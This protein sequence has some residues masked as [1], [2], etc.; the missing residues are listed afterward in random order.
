M[1]EYHITK[2]CLSQEFVPDWYGSGEKIEIPNEIRNYAKK[3]VSDNCLLGNK[4]IFENQEVFNSAFSEYIEEKKRDIEYDWQDL[5]T[6]SPKR[7][8]KVLYGTWFE[9]ILG[10][11]LS[12]RADYEDVRKNSVNGITYEQDGVNKKLECDV[13]C[14]NDKKKHILLM[15][16]KS[17]DLLD[18]AKKTGERQKF[19]NKKAILEKKYIGY[20]IDAIYYYNKVKHG[21]EGKEKIKDYYIISTPEE[22]AN[23][24]KFSDYEFMLFKSCIFVIKEIVKEYNKKYN[25]I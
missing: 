3:I 15:E 18:D 5:D 14:K 25:I 1:D 23:H 13:L 10:K 17:S 16:I 19:L 4:H 20:K 11:I 2:S 6:F 21:K 12:M 9:I 7:N 22:L 24:L 8:Q